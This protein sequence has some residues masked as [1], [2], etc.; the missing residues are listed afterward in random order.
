MFDAAPSGQLTLEI[1]PGEDEWGTRSD[2]RWRAD[3][4]GLRREIER[5][6]PSAV[7]PPAA[8][9]GTKGVEVLDVI[10]TL[11]TAGVFT[12]T[13]EAFRAWLQHKPGRRSIVVRW[14]SRDE[15]GRLRSG[16][17]TVTGENVDSN[18]LSVVSSEVFK[19]SP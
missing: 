1:V 11:G 5:S 12:A 3:L 8:A 9:P 14:T 16:T 10:V 2:D 17:T 18:D 6:V 4:L 19:G 7:V 15:D 13:V